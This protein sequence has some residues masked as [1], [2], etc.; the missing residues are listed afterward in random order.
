MILDG[1]KFSISFL[2]DNSIKLLLIVSIPFILE[3]LINSISAFYLTDA[4]SFTEFVSGLLTLLIQT[5]AQCML[6][7]YI[8]NQAANRSISDI[9]IYTKIKKAIKEKETH[10]PF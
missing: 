1:F 5:W 3:L 2:K 8:H 6:I 4:S 10:N 7:F 9:S